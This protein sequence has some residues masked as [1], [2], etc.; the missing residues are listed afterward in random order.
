MD[1]LLVCGL[2]QPPDYWRLFCF[3]LHRHDDPMQGEP[4]WMCVS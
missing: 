1:R 2:A 4:V 3:R